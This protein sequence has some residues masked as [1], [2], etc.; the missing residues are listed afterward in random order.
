MMSRDYALTPDDRAAAFS[1]AL[2]A[3]QREE[4]AKWNVPEDQVERVV[5]PLQAVRRQL[6]LAAKSSVYEQPYRALVEE[7]RRAG[8]V[9]RDE[10]EGKR[11]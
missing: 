7:A 3:A 11:R 8:K 1:R 4:A 9:S 10:Q 5:V 2:G 6:N